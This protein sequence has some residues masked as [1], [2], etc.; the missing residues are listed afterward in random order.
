M[1][2][3]IKGKNLPVT[4]ALHEHAQRKLE[5]LTR[6]LPPWDEPPEVEL[7]LSV[8]RNPSIELN[9]VCELTVRTKGPVLRVREND[10][11]MYVAIDHAVHKLERQA[12]RYRDRKR[13]RHHRH[14]KHDSLPEP[15]LP[16][17]LEAIPVPANPLVETTNEMA[18]IVDEPVLRVVKAK[19]FEMIPMSVDDAADRIELLSHDF[20]VV[21]NTED[22]DAVTVIYRRRDGDLGLIAPSDGGHA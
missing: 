8:E 12:A 20:Y 19:R 13:R 4:D 10:R 21:K 9:Q 18:D 6:F 1:E 22:D 14:S 5:K 11:D 7:E 15:V 3:R 16:K 2:V 17:D